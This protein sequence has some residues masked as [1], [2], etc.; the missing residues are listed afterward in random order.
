M[1]DQENGYAFGSDLFDQRH[2]LDLLL[3]RGAGGRLVEEQ[4]P[5]VAGKRAGDLQAPLVAVG[6]VPRV[7]V[8][9]L[10]DADELQ[11]L[12][13][14]LGD[15]DLLDSLPLGFEE[16]VPHFGVHPRMLTDPHVVEGGHVGEEPNLL[17]GP[18]DAQLGNPVGLE[19]GDV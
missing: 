19:P 17:K 5:R 10:L 14:L 8:R 15:A 7:I 16:G 2:Q 18:S 6:Q 13:R 4:Q 9:V 11:E 1:L 12:H 3:R